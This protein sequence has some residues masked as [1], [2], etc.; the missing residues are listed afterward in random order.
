MTTAEALK[1]LRDAEQQMAAESRRMTVVLFHVYD[2][3][4]RTY[5]TTPRR[6]RTVDAARKAAREALRE[7]GG[8]VT[9]SENGRDVV[10]AR[11]ASE[12]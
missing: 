10:K 12:V 9:I 4:E 11:K 3:G 8:E 1:I 6:F 7:C 5:S 2:D